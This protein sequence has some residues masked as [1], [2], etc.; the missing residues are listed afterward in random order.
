MNENEEDEITIKAKK[1]RKFLLLKTDQ[2]INAYSKRHSNIM[3]NSKTTEELHNAYNSYTIL[4]S[5]PSSIYSN[6]VQTI[7]KMFPENIQKQ[8]K[9]KEIPK[10]HFEEQVSKSL[11]SSLDSHSPAIDFVPNK[12]DLG[13]KKFSFMMKKGSIKNTKSPKFLDKINN[14]QENKINEEE[15]D[16]TKIK[17]S[18][19]GKK[20]IHKVID[21]IVRIKLTNEIEDDNNITKNV[22][23]LR[24]Y[25]YKLIKRKKR[26][27]MHSKTKVPLSFKKQKKPN[28]ERPILRK[29]KTLVNL[30]I[31]AKRSLFGLKDSTQEPVLKREDTFEKHNDKKEN[32]KIE[33]EKNS[34][35]S[36]AISNSNEHKNYK[37]N[38]FKELKTVREKTKEYL[39]KKKKYR[40]TQ[41][42]N[43]GKEPFSMEN[44][45]NH[46]KEI[47][48]VET[49]SRQANMNP[50]LKEPI[51]STKFARPSKFLII[52]NNINNA[53]IIIKKE[54]KKK[55]SLFGNKRSDLKILKTIREKEKDKICVRNSL[56]KNP[57]HTVKLFSPAFKGIK[58]NS[59][60]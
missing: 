9:E 26:H 18:K 22:I 44:K 23:K 7:Q 41:T 8:T 30:H 11:N 47:K 12:I 50:L 24:K 13:K 10:K 3:I 34:E 20:N 6:Y 15:E 53:N 42:I 25:C 35:K 29:R 32:V 54:V 51:I 27:K 48:K 58:M 52:N 31:F 43:I 33:E 57:K 39:E 46:K 14:L 36:S 38:S 5:V 55:N 56:K 40:R 37:M 28:L 16:E 1:I 17:S 2:D 49:V 59:D 60:S 4:L 45:M 19:L 21:K